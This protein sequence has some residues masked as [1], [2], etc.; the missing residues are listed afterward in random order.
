MKTKKQLKI[1]VLGS[2]TSQGVPVIGCDCEVCRSEDPR[3]QRL[4]CSVLIESP[5]TTVVIDCG[6]DFRQQMLRAGVKKLDAI[7]LTHEHNDHVI[8]LDDV[9]PFNFSQGGEMPVFGKAAVLEELKRRF[10]YVFATHPYPGA[11]RIRPV[12]IEAGTPLRVGDLHILPLLV[13][14]GKLPVLGFRVGDFAYLTDVKTLPDETIEQ[15]RGINCLIISALHHNLHH[16]HLNLT[17]AL[18]LIERIAPRQ[19]YLTHI[20]HRMGRYETIIQSLPPGV[21]PAFDGLELTLPFTD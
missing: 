14:H 8:G 15:V 12:P 10:A 21:L 4:R 2:G 5:E 20:S 6:P 19:A 13:W 3:D 7:L 1:T 9:R 16:S 11:P 18:E 17:E